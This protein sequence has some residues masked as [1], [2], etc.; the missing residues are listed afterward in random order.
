MWKNQ[1]IYKIFGNPNDLFHKYLKSFKDLYDNVTE[2]ANSFSLPNF[3]NAQAFRLTKNKDADVVNIH[4]R[5]I[6]PN[7]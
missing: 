4:L 1:R 2:Q 7:H 6:Q 5:F 3:S